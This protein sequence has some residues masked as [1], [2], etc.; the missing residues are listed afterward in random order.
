MLT[1]VITIILIAIISLGLLHVT[2]NSIHS[3]R[4]CVSALVNCRSTASYLKTTVTLAPAERF[5]KLG[6]KNNLPTLVT[7]TYTSF[8]RVACFIA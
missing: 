7:D 3:V 6:G 8:V 5:C 1:A 4:W 2:H